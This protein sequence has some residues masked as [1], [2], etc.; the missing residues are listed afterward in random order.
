MYRLK[1]GVN[2]GKPEWSQLKVNMQ[3][4]PGPPIF[5]SA[6]GE[7]KENDVTHSICMRVI[8]HV[9]ARL[10]VSLCILPMGCFAFPCACCISGFPHECVYIYYLWQSWRIHQCKWPFEPWWHFCFIYFIKPHCCFSD[11]LQC[12]CR[13]SPLMRNLSIMNTAYTTKAL[14]IH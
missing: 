13:R 7:W 4:H 8:T 1:G 9:C 10:C 11:T 12:I 6:T 3:E 14:L 2:K 5:L